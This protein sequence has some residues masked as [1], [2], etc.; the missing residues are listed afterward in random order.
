[1]LLDN[2]NA[3]IFFESTSHGGTESQQDMGSRGN[4]LST[5]VSNETGKRIALQWMMIEMMIRLEE[6]DHRMRH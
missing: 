5:K 6:E 2:F 1:M 4:S 3:H